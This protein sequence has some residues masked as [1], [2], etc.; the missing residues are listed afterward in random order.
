MITCAAHY[1]RH[2]NTDMKNTLCVGSINTRPNI[3]TMSDIT[4][5]SA[6]ILC[7]PFRAVS[8]LMLCIVD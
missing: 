7:V 8:P 5:Y 6:L 3:I 1:V 2:K 4:S